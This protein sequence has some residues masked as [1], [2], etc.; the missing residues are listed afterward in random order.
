MIQ[1]LNHESISHNPFKSGRMGW[2][3]MSTLCICVVPKA[4]TQKSFN[5]HVVHKKVT[6]KS[7]S[8]RLK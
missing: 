4:Q 6:Q 5:D 2:C 7:H 1:G 8:N 3:A